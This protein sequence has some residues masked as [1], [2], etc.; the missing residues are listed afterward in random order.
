VL[1]AATLQGIVDDHALAVISSDGELGRLS[2]RLDRR[3][4][5]KPLDAILL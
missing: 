4:L 5:G 1:T 3:C 2:T